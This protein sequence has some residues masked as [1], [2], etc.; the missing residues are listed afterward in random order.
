M[1]IMCHTRE[2]RRKAKRQTATRGED[3]GGATLSSNFIS[4]STKGENS[5]VSEEKEAAHRWKWKKRREIPERKTSVEFVKIQ[6]PQEGK[7]NLPRILTV[8]Q[9]PSHHPPRYPVCVCCNIKAA[10]PVGAAAHYYV[11]SSY[12]DIWPGSDGC[13]ER[14]SYFHNRNS[15]AQ[16][17]HRSL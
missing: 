16:Q 15:V 14:V 13:R 4:F 5:H 10:S 7:W 17:K 9:P 6:H 8:R 1:K 2:I 3:I 11:I 12:C